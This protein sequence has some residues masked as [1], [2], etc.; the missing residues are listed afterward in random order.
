VILNL[1]DYY[2]VVDQMFAI[3]CDTISSNTGAFSGAIS[4]LTKAL[5][6][7]ILG[8]SVAIISVRSKFPTSWKNSLAKYK[9][10][11]EGSLCLSA[12]GTAFHQVDKMK[13]LVRFDRRKLQVGRMAREA[14]EF[15]FH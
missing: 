3:C 7:F 5:N 1:L 12:E 11:K 2:E 6:I 10:P 9:R 15:H 4:V 14:L 8:F 13:N